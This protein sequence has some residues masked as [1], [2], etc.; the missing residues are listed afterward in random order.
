MFAIEE[1]EIKLRRTYFA[2]LAKVLPARKAARYI[3]LESRLHTQLR[4]EL[5]TTLPLAG[6][7]RKA[8]PAVG[9]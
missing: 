1:A 4:H 6:D 8:A 5:A 9:K 3:Q 7:A 2:R